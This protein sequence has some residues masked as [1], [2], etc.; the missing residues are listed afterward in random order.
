[1]IRI[2]T[3]RDATWA[4]AVDDKGFIK[5]DHYG[6]HGERRLS[7]REAIDLAAALTQSVQDAIYRNQKGTPGFHRTENILR[8]A[9]SPLG[10]AITALKRVYG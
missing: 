7:H 3:E 10:Q 8:R 2:E 9:E 4:V 6:H 1:M 5:L